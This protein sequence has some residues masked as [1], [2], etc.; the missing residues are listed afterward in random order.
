[1]KFRDKMIKA[2]KDHAKGHIAKHAMNVEVYFRNAA[3][4]GGKDNADILEEIEK[5]LDVVARY[6]DQIEML[7]KYFVDESSQ[8]ILF[9]DMN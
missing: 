1:M 4:I 3:G 8:Q 2:M 5:E 9:E 7:D 6:H